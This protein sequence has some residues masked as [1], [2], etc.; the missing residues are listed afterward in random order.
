MM[1]ERTKKFLASIERMDEKRRQFV[2]DVKRLYEFGLLDDVIE[3]LAAALVD[4][5]Y[6]KQLWQESCAA[7]RKEFK[8]LLEYN[9]KL[10]E[11]Y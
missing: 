11:K 9:K 2:N 8:D 6:Y 5:M 10:R 7:A 1:T 4:E 3:M